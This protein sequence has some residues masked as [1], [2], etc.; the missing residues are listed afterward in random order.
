MHVHWHER[1][2]FGE[3][4]PEDRCLDLL[5]EAAVQFVF[6]LEQDIDCRTGSG[7][8]V[9]VEE[10]R[11]VELT[12]DVHH[13]VAAEAS[14]GAEL[15]DVTCAVQSSKKLHELSGDGVLDSELGMAEAQLNSVVTQPGWGA[16]EDRE[17]RQM[18]GFVPPAWVGGFELRSRVSGAS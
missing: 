10:P 5:G 18:G 6:D 17:V 1:G 8:D 7:A 12:Q 11:D 2:A 16:N 3:L 13:F 15:F 4:P 9:V 14:G